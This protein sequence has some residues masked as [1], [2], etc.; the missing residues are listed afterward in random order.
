M[1]GAREAK[2]PQEN[3]QNQLTWAHRGPQRLNPQ[4]GSLR[5][6]DLGPLYICDSCVAWA[7]CGLSCFLLC[8]GY[9]GFLLPSFA[10]LAIWI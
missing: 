10:V 5:E 8:S 7:S 2:T 3:P 6:T 9:G 4:P 1:V